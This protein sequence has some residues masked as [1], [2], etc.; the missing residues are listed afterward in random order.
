[1]AAWCLG[2]VIGVIAAM[3]LPYGLFS[4]IGWLLVGIVLLAPLANVRQAWILLI[5]VISGAFVGLWRGGVGQIGLDQYD[6]LIGQQVIVHGVISED[7]DVDKRGQTVL[8]VSGISVQGRE[9][10]GNVWVVTPKNDVLRRSDAV[11]VSGKM[12]EGFGAF[13]GAMYRA[14][15]VNVERALPGNVAVNVRD[16]FAER[17]RAHVPVPEVDLGLGYLL[18]LR[19]ALPTD[20]A[21]ALKIAGLT[22]VIVAS[23]YNLTILVRLSRRLFVRISKYLSML[24]SVGMILAFMAVTGLSPSMSRAG[25]VAGLSL[26]AWYYGRTVHPFVLLPFSAAITLLINPQFGWNDLGWQLSFAAFAGVIILA[27]LLQRYFFGDKEP[28]TIRQVV[29]ETFS[30]QIFTLPLLVMAFGVVSNVALLANVLI[31]PLVPLAMLLVFLAGIFATVP[32]LGALIA[33]PTTWLLS[34]M[35]WVAEWLAGQSW[36]QMEVSITWWMVVL[37]YIVLSLAVWWMVH[38]TGYRLRESN[39]VQ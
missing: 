26:A 18:G 8:R 10:P 36:A 4:G 25:L 35:V 34:Y 11:T 23:G 32:L 17:V 7:P 37:A 12:T 33:A 16:W 1:V 13:A 14:E 27:P 39:V 22:H 19:R 31:L 24:S 38:A 9:L 5:V 20:L 28:G 6:N 30:A 29:G 3:S 2:V 21:E 15:I